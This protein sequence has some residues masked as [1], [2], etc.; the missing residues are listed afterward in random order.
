MLV[1]CPTRGTGK[2][3]F[4]KMFSHAN[5]DGPINF[6]NISRRP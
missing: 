2:Q 5:H 1:I 3:I 6:I 4:K